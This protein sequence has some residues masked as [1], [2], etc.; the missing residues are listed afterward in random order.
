MVQLKGFDDTE[1]CEKELNF[2]TYMVQLKD[3]SS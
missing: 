3:Q 2:N 1:E